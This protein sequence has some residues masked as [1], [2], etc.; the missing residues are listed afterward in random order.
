MDVEEWEGEEWEGE[1][2]EGDDWYADTRV[3]W[4]E[5]VQHYGDNSK[6]HTAERTGKEEVSSADLDKPIDKPKCEESK[7]VE[8]LRNHDSLPAESPEDLQK[9]AEDK[10]K[11]LKEKSAPAEMKVEQKPTKGKGK[12]VPA[13]VGKPEQDEAITWVPLT[14]SGYGKFASGQGVHDL[15]PPATHQILDSTKQTDS[16][17]TWTPVTREGAEQFMI[18]CN[19]AGQSPVELEMLPLREMIILLK[20]AT[21]PEV[22]QKHA[23][24]FKKKVPQHVNDT[25]HAVREMWMDWGED[26]LEAVSYWLMEWSQPQPCNCSD[27]FEIVQINLM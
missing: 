13:H 27:Q 12:K 21:V 23:T 4:A 14:K 8:N 5:E 25:L 18:L 6:D 26:S 22:I 2:W 9:L 19:Q 20:D 3:S 17:V 1:K 11:P 7:A 10:K 24:K 16:M 15:A